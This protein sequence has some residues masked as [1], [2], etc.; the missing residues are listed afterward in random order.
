MDYENRFVTRRFL[1]LSQDY[2]FGDLQKLTLGSWDLHFTTGID[3]CP[4][5][6]NSVN[7]PG[8]L[9]GQGGGG[10]ER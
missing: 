1:T 8:L 2:E 10:G 3:L 7:M 9:C 4:P 6:A 5:E